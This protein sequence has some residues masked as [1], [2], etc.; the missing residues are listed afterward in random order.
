M[1]RVKE[2]EEVKE[3]EDLEFEDVVEDEFIEEEVQPQPIQDW[4]DVDEQMEETTQDKEMEVEV[5]EEKEEPAQP[6]LG[7][8]ELNE[9]EQLVYENSAYQMIHRAN[10]EWP[11]LTIDVLLNDRLNFSESDSWFPG[12]VNK[13]PP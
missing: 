9:E 10:C 8:T 6:W 1:K 3:E 7:N 5:E 2:L 12:S 13:I 11:C 4:E